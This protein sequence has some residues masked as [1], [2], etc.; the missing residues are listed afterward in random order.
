MA[1]VL[2]SLVVVLVTPALRAQASLTSIAPLQGPVGATVTLTG[3]GFTGASAVRFAGHDAAFRVV[4]DDQVSAVVPPGAETGSVEIDTVDGSLLSPDRFLVQPNVLLIV[5]DD[6][7]WDTVVSMPR[8][9]SDIAG[10]GV[11]FANMFVT[12]PLCCPSRATLLTGRYS[13]S[14]GV[15]SNKA[16]FGGFTTFEDDDTVATALDAE[17]YRTGMFGKYLNQYTATGG[18]YVP[19]GWDRWRA[20]L[21]GGYFDYT[22]S[23]D[24]IS[25]ESYGSAPEDYST[26]VLADQAA[27]FIQDTSPQDPLLVWFAPLAPHEPFIPAPRHVGT[28]AGLAAWRPPS[29][30]EPDVSDK[31]F[32]IRNAPRLSTDR[33]AEIDALRQAQLETLMA[34]DDAVAQLLTTLAV[35]GRLEDTLI[36]FTSD[37]GYLWGEHRRAG[38][39]VPYEESIRVPLTIRWDRLPG[40]APTRTRLV[41]NLD[42]AP[43]IL[44][45]AE[46]TLPGVEGESLLPLLNG[47]TGAWRSQMLFEHYGEG[48][49]SYC[50][51]RTKDL[52]FVHYRTGE[53]EFYRLA[54][55]PYERMN[56]IASTT[57]AERIASLRDAARARCNPLPPDMTPF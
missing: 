25:Q 46:A 20:F 1:A 22:L 2:A 35:M 21:N 32:Y 54:T 39:V 14:T 34:V 51:I 9:Q 27:G 6:Q 17:G 11:S 3:S 42:I 48:A 19:P 52:L 31:P 8:V 56:R 30:N 10:Q 18:T 55:D 50:A 24:G 41:Q 23:L 4:G 57:A 33:Q 28:L 49:P 37:N 43:T 38:K 44:D 15:W 36:V 45:A 12:N 29:Y 7:R 26:D 47:A 40:T 53:E 13:H 5:T 16:P